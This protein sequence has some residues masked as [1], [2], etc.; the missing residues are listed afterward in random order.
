MKLIKKM[1]YLLEGKSLVVQAYP[2][3]AV[4]CVSAPAGMASE[5]MFSFS[6]FFLKTLPVCLPIS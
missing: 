4:F 2:A 3:R 6:D 1:N 5:A